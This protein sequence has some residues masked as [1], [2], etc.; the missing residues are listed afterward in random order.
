M[1]GP[2]RRPTIDQI[3]SS[4][5]VNNQNIT[6]ESALAPQI[7]QKQKK[8]VSWLSRGR[9]RRKTV[10]SS[11]DRTMDI[12]LM[13]L[14]FNT[15]RANSVLEENF[16]HPIVVPPPQ[17]VIDDT[18]VHDI[19]KKTRGRSLFGNSLK[20]KIGPIEEK[21]KGDLFNRN[22]IETI[23]NEIKL[24]K[25][26]NCIPNSIEMISNSNINTTMT[27]TTITTNQIQAQSSIGHD[28]D[29]EQGEFI[30][31]PTDTHDLTDL[32]PLE[33][34]A[35]QILD[36]LGITSEMLCRSIESGP[37]SEIIGAYRIVIYRLQRQKL[38]AKSTEQTVIE[39][40]HFVKLKS[41]NSN[42]HFN[43]TCVIL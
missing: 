15:K 41:S 42:N 18:T 37:R 12:N 11:Q 21:T 2:S 8:N 38:M 25:Q 40:E 35:R 1:H 30:M 27:R 4:Q 6:L 5:W 10:E 16:L 32:N 7:K 14:Y 33:R 23:N 3:L 36:K 24:S 26:I 20:K 28:D 13:R 29:E 9:M 17:A 43:R 39:N 34:E 31:S 22:G 19:Q